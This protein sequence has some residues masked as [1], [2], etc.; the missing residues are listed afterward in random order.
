M[1]WLSQFMGDWFAGW[2]G[3]DE[4]GSGITGVASITEADDSLTASAEITGETISLGSA[5]Y[6][7]WFSRIE[8]PR[9]RLQPITAAAAI[10]EADDS[11]TGSAALSLVAVAHLTEVDDSATGSARLLLS[12]TAAITEGD[13]SAAI[14]ATI[15]PAFGLEE[16]ELV[17]LL[18]A[19]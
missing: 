8:S 5:G 3:A 16:D 2:F 11:A 18:A 15:R 19:A 6:P 4:A 1:N 12:A 7:Q 14:T 13:D 9:R 10:T 17:A